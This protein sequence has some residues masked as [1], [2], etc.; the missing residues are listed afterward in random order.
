MAQ[1]LIIG[2]HAFLGGYEMVR[3]LVIGNHVFLGGYEMTAV[4]SLFDGLIR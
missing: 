3:V 2:N 4:K 1:V